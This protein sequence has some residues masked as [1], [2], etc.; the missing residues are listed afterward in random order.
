[1]KKL[2]C[3]EQIK[4]SVVIPFCDDLQSLDR[5]LDAV[6]AESKRFGSTEVILVDNGSKLDYQSLTH[7]HEVRIIT[8][9]EK[10]N[11]PYSARNR[12]IEVS[13]GGIIVLLDA[14]CIP[15]PGWLAAGVSALDEKS[16]DIV[17]GEV[18]FD[19]N[20]ESSTAEIYDALVNIRM[21][22]SIMTRQVA[23]TANLFIRRK[24]FEAI[25]LFAEGVRSGE[26]VG[27]TSRAVEYGFRLEFSSEAVVV[28]APRRLREV[29]RKQ[30]R[31]ATWQ[32]RIRRAAQG[33]TPKRN[34]VK[35][36]LPRLII[37]PGTLK[38][39]MLERD[40]DF[41]SQFGHKIF[42]ITFLHN[43]IRVWMFAGNVW[44]NIKLR[45]AKLVGRRV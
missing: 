25:G 13:K 8:E 43:F 20:E 38:K 3:P 5:S 31:V 6:L 18:R 26:D 39:M 44:G 2:P 16:A 34:R 14:T 27:W 33:Q 19:I 42:Q 36:S 22:E 10:L 7:R 21:K 12:G 1:M 37:P 28:K 29:L 35:R 24:V 40:D 45:K 30:W 17:G 23:K 32:P 9:L 41:F 4:L 15:R 11:S